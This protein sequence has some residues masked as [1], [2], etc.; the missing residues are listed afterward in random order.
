MEGP[1]CTTLNSLD[2]LQSEEETGLVEEAEAAIGAALSKWLD[3]RGTHTYQHCVKAV[4][5]RQL[6]LRLKGSDLGNEQ[7][8]DKKS[9]RRG[10][11]FVKASSE[12]N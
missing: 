6:G 10:A 11:V 1:L 8:R 5:S 4:G 3:V 12:R 9:C 7:L 2:V